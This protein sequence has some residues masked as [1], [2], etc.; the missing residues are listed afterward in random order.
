LP[1][2]V[3]TEMHEMVLFKLPAN[4]DLK[5]ALNSEEEPPIEFLGA[6]VA[7]PGQTAPTLLVDSLAAGRYAMVCFFETEEGTP[8]WQL[9]MLADFTVGAAQAT[10]TPTATATKTATP[11]ATPTA[12]ATATAVRG[13][14]PV[15]PKT[16]NGGL[17]DDDGSVP[18]ALLL[19]LGLAVVLGGSATT[20]ATRKRRSS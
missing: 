15:P 9:G 12:T 7:A 17:L 10:P 16:G 20:Y 13:T 3:G 2:N 18:G 6:T 8:H 5:A 4:L 19:V 14:T 11:A 1:S